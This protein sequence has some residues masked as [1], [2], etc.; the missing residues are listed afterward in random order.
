MYNKYTVYQ[1]DI[2]SRQQ[3]IYRE[4]KEHRFSPDKVCELIHENL[5]SMDFGNLSF[6]LLVLA[7]LSLREPSDV[8]RR[9][10]DK[11]VKK[12][13]DLAIPLNCKFISLD[14]WAMDK[15]RVFD[16]QKAGK[17]LS[18]YMLLLELNEASVIS[19]ATTANYY[20]KTESLNGGDYQQFFIAL[21][22]AF[23]NKLGAYFEGQCTISPQ[24]LL[25]TLGAI[26]KHQRG[27]IQEQIELAF[28]GRTYLQKEVRDHR[29]FSFKDISMAINLFYEGAGEDKEI[30]DLITPILKT[31]LE[32]RALENR[33]Q[34]AA[35]DLAVLSDKYSRIYPRYSEIV[36]Q[37]AFCFQ[38]MLLKQK[39]TPG[40]VKP[41][42]AAQI[43]KAFSF[44]PIAAD[45]S[46][47][48]EQIAEYFENVGAEVEVKASDYYMLQDSFQ[49]A[50]FFHPV[51]NRLQKNLYKL[52]PVMGL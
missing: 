31:K 20:A 10:A 3:T 4:L 44:L 41:I 47:L 35:H 23:C 16:E 28:Y 30:W 6:S 9:L 11:C 27:H 18:A 17:L 8:F 26:V 19:I 39:I 1:E 33:D 43:A 45:F 7:K 52:K 48:F 46:P 37:L 42:D 24:D 36:G 21:T 2:L 15:L 12:I 22:R 50:Q 40:V 34:L 29:E 25:L 32:N 14:F 51:L 38:E 13:G 49:R 5:D